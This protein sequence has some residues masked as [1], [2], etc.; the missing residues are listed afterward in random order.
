[1][2]TLNPFMAAPP[3]SPLICSTSQTLA[4][5]TDFDCSNVGLNYV[6]VT[7]TNGPNSNSC[8]SQVEVTN[9]FKLELFCNSSIL[10]LNSSAQAYL[11][12]S[13]VS[14]FTDNCGPVQLTSS[15]SSQTFGC[16]EIGLITYTIFLRDNYGNSAQCKTNV[17]IQDKTPP[18]VTCNNGS[19]IDIQETGVALVRAS[20]LA[21]VGHL[22]CESPV[23]LT[24]N[25]SS[26][27]CS[28]I[29]IHHLEIFAKDGFGNVGTCDT[30]VQVVDNI[31]PSLM[32]QT[33]VLSLNQ[34]G[35]SLLIPLQTVS[36]FSDNCGKV[37]LSLPIDQSPIFDCSMI[38]NHIVEITATDSSNNTNICES[39][40]RVVDEIFPL[41]VCQPD[42][43]YLSLN[44]TTHQVSLNLS[45]VISNL[46]DNCGT[47]SLTVSQI[48]FGCS[49]IG[50]NQVLITATDSSG[51]S[52]S[53]KLMVMINQTV[54]CRSPSI[55]PLPSSSNFTSMSELSLY[56]SLSPIQTQIPM[57]SVS[58]SASKSSTAF[59]S[60]S[61][62]SSSANSFRSFSQSL[63]STPSF[64]GSFL[65]GG[66]I[67]SSPPIFHSFSS[68]PTRTLSPSYSPFPSL[69]QCAPKCDERLVIVLPAGNAS[70][71]I[72]IVPSYQAETKGVTIFIVNTKG[73]IRGSIFLSPS[74][75]SSTT[76]LTLSPLQ[77]RDPSNLVSTRIDVTLFNS[78]G[79][80]ISQFK[81]KVT[82]CLHTKESV[83][84]SDVSIASFLS[85][86]LRLSETD[87][88]DQNLCL[89]FYATSSRS[90]ICQDK[91]LT[92]SNESMVC[93]QTNHFTNFAVLL[94]GITSGCDPQFIFGKAI[95]DSTLAL[96]IA[97]LILIFCMVILILGSTRKGREWAEGGNFK[98][99]KTKNLMSTFQEVDD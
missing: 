86:D 2:A 71:S 17:T 69:S 54:L 6:M 76:N 85:F 56:S 93:G 83:S 34:T 5:K 23:S 14:N 44:S 99:C 8:V 92:P 36:S 57:I 28:Q 80:E 1:M 13:T 19:I 3:S 90:W 38:G 66:E 82:V 97:G 47:P 89:G 98:N 35:Y 62:P 12:L 52:D 88:K 20:D 63:S 87:S 39:I 41:V 30:T 55:T 67:L 43:L 78:Q 48:D 94:E 51:N 64:T 40:I 74:V 37:N 70:N 42:V 49:D 79:Q 68:S 10:T 26:F 16:N 24:A 4:N 65:S 32:C 11:N 45:G 77:I 22:L 27:D 21:T 75:A 59:S 31:P 84:K 73:E 53:C 33:V 91:C 25:V 61:I 29:G 95:Y 9:P 7:K 60:S 46:T 50:I 96:G 58:L 72:D 15:L 81:D 18:P